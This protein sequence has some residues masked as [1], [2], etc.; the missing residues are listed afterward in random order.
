[1]HFDFDSKADRFQWFHHFRSVL[2]STLKKKYLNIQVGEQS[3]KVK[4]MD[5][6]Y[7]IAFPETNVFTVRNWG[8][9]NAPKLEAIEKVR[10]TWKDIDELIIQHIQTLNKGENKKQKMIDDLIEQRDNLLEVIK[11]QKEL[12]KNLSKILGD[13]N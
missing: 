8:L 7:N 9:R 4:T 2:K 10:N 12:I 1:M 3:F 13:Q 6:F 11:N 5:D